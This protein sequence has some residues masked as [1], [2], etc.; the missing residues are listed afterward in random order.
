M[1][2]KTLHDLLEL[3]QKGARTER[4]QAITSNQGRNLPFLNKALKEGLKISAL[5]GKKNV[6]YI[7]GSI[8][9]IPRLM[10]VDTGANVTLLRTDM[11][12]K[13]KEQFIYT[14]PNISLKTVTGEKAEI[15][16]KLDESIECGS[17]KFHLR[18]YLADITNP[19]VL[20]PDFLQ[21]LNL[22]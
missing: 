8:C 4:C 9:D 16:G 20:D 2:R 10:L 3:Q 7:V 15:H 21:K 14:V 6:L 12:Q 13:L 1:G 11:A 17:R 5:S 22:L 18:I 19:C